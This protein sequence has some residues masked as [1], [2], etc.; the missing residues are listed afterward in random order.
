MIQPWVA[1]STASHS[2]PSFWP[3]SRRCQAMQ[4]QIV[5]YLRQCLTAEA[6]LAEIA[7]I[8]E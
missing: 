6:R 3:E 2:A 8:V 5:L 4:E 1:G 7:L